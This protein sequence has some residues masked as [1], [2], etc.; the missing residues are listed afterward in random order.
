MP[1]ASGHWRG[2]GQRDR[3]NAA[4]ADRS[5]IIG[6]T[7]ARL[8]ADATAQG[9][10][11]FDAAGQIEP[12]LAERWIVIDDGISYIFRLRDAEWADGEPVTADQV[13]ALAQAPAAPS[14]RNPLA[15]FL[16][17]IDE[18]VEMT[19]QV[20]E[21]RLK[22]PRP[23]LLKLFAQPELA[24]FRTG[25]QRQRPFPHRHRWTS[26]APP[27]RGRPR[28]RS[29]TRPPSRARRRMSA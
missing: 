9:L 27:P 14:S 10:V 3:R 1:A 21:V 12:G 26:A 4:L 29:R 7:P 6:D 11:R 22:R 23:D 2:G 24:L 19:P 25:R 15:P 5:R 28:S 13:V 20:I 17:A 18:I 16:T 8:F